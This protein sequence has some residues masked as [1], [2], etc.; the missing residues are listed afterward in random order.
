M[1]FYNYLNEKTFKLTADS[2]LLYNEVSFFC[3]IF[4][5]T[6]VDKLITNLS[7]VYNGN[8]KILFESDTSILKSKDAQKAHILNPANIYVGIFNKGS[9]YSPKEVL[10]GNP[11]KSIINISFHKQALD[12]VFSGRSGSIPSHQIKRFWNEFKPDKIKATIAHELSHWMNDSIN[13]RNITNLLVTAKE[14]SD[15]DIITLKK[16]NVNM[17]HFELDAQVHALKQIKAN[18]RKLWDT[19]TLLDVFQ[20]Y[21]PL[22][23]IADSLKYKPKSFHIWQKALIKRLARENLLGKNMKNFVKKEEI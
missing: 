21:T 5:E 12:L 14:L 11:S 9:Y 7:K 8:E 3:D 18:N 17:T 23:T 19:W 13:N 16:D 2:N 20:V 1:K 22:H 4:K 15:P 10:P 6:D